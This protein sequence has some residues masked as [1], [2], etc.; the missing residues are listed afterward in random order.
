RGRRSCRPGT[1]WLPRRTKRQPRDL[2]L[3]GVSYHFS[4]LRRRVAETRQRR[5]GRMDALEREPVDRPPAEEA[6]AHVEGGYQQARREREAD[7]PVLEAER[8]LA[9]DLLPLAG[10][11]LVRLEVAA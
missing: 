5:V 1:S 11:E 9:R 7:R 2:P 6:A 4:S 10:I 3:D 8:R